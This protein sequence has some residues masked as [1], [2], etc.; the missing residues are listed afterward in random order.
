MEGGVESEPGET[1]VD[2]DGAV[3]VVPV[4]G[5][6]ATFRGSEGGGLASECGVSG[7]VARANDFDPPLED[8]A[9]GGLAGF[10][11][12]E[13]R[14]DG[15]FDDSADPGDIRDRLGSGNY[16]DVAGGGT[17]HLNESA[18]GHAGPNDAIVDVEFTNAKGMPTGRPSLAAHA[19]Q[20]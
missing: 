15:A 9:D 10:V 19:G 11:S 14:Q 8:V 20:R 4:E 5:E 13:T 3:A 1:L 6:Q 17:D 2:E 18:F 12:V 16:A 7:I